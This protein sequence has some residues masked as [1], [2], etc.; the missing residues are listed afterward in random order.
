MEIFPLGEIIRIMRKLQQNQG[1]WQKPKLP[2]DEIRARVNMPALPA[3]LSKDEMIL[4][5]HNERRVELA[6][7]E[8]RYFDLRR[9]QK[10]EGNLNATCQWLTGMRITK[11]NDGSF[12]YQR[13]NISTNPRGG[14]QNRDLLL[15]LPLDEVSRLESTTG[16]SWQNQGW[17]IFCIT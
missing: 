15:P 1:I 11:N 6:W 9:W 2:W 8:V 13:Y 16:V 12:N 14:Y 10:P 5:V 4:R 3:G 17:I 7:E